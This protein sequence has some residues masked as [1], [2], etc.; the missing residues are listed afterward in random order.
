MGE[1]IQAI[2][3]LFLLGFGTGLFFGVLSRGVSAVIGIFKHF[4]K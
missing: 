3:F 2:F 4:I 1:V